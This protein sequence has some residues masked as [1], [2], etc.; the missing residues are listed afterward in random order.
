MLSEFF[1]E[2]KHF[3][4]LVC[5]SLYMNISFKEIVAGLSSSNPGRE[6]F[7]KLMTTIMLHSCFKYFNN[8]SL[9]LELLN[10]V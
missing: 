6:I 7:R 5:L 1:V 9:L 3:D 8:S 4:Y 10:L 2:L